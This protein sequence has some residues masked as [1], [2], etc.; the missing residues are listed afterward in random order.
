MAPTE[1][2]ITFAVIC[3]LAGWPVGDVV[4]A[5]VTFEAVEEVDD[6]VW[7]ALDDV[8]DVVEICCRSEPPLLLLAFEPGKPLVYG[9]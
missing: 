5:D 2:N 1:P 3:V 6:L 4:D 7:Y 8:A 9:V